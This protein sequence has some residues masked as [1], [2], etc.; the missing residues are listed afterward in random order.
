MQIDYLLTPKSTNCNIANRSPFTCPYHNSYLFVFWQNQ[1]HEACKDYIPNGSK[2]L[3]A[4]TST[5]NL[6][7][8]LSSSFFTAKSTL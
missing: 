7:L 5:S 4:P 8:T 6:V 3:M 1:R 2:W